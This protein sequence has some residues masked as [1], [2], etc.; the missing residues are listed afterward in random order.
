MRLQLLL[1]LSY[2][3]QDLKP[4]SSPNVHLAFDY[5]SGTIFLSNNITSPLRNLYF[6]PPAL[7]VTGDGLLEE[8]SYVRSLPKFDEHVLAHLL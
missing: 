5:D 7:K 3:P 4:I 6:K 8:I 1:I 2:L